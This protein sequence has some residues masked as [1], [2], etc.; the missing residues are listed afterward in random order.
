MKVF[1]FRK[2]GNT[3]FVFIQRQLWLSLFFLC[4]S[5]YAYAYANANANANRD[6]LRVLFVGNSYIYYNNLIQMVSLLSDSMETK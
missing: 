5:A 4:L 3:A 6:T 2:I 1:N